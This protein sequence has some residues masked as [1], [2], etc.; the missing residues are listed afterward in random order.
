MNRRC[1]SRWLSQ[2]ALDVAS[3]LCELVQ[4]VFVSGKVYAPPFGMYI[5]NSPSAGGTT[6]YLVHLASEQIQVAH[7]PL[8]WSY[9]SIRGMCDGRVAR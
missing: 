7:P 9:E 2:E 8:C 6:P 1:P 4:Y 3:C 5:K